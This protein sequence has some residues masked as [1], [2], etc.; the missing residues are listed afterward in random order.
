MRAQ[1]ASVYGTQCAALCLYYSYSGGG[2][3]KRMSVFYITELVIGYYSV[4]F[5]SCKRM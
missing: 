2:F 4:L 3:R 5:N 1:D